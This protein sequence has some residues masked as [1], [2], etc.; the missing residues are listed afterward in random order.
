VLFRSGLFFTVFISY[1]YP[2]IVIGSLLLSIALSKGRALHI[3]TGQVK[4]SVF[5]VKYLQRVFIWPHLEYITDYFRKL[6]TNGWNL[7]RCNK[8]SEAGRWF[9]AE[10]Y[11]LHILVTV[12]PQFLMLLPLIWQYKQMLPVER[13]FLVWMA[14]GLFFFFITKLKW[15]LFLGEGE[16]YLEYALFPSLF[17]AVKYFLEFNES[18]V[19]GFLIYSIVSAFYYVG[20]YLICYGKN[21]SDYM[22]TDFAFKQF[23]NM[24]SGVIWPIGSFHYQ[25]L[26]RSNFPVL[27][28]GGNIDE[29]LISGA[30]FMLVYG[31]YP[32]PSG[33]FEKIIE[34]Y[35][36]SYIVSNKSSVEYYAETIVKRPEDFYN[37]VN[38]LFET[39]TL[40]A[41]K[42]K[43]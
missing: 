35:N 41:Y 5:Y 8:V 31:N 25:A 3:I 10:R 17:I 19:Y 12:Y 14:A 7:L 26:Y 11:F 34:K 18:I 24:P 23:N 43:M 4:H 30:E 42:V 40:V 38:L 13:F 33:N 27:S 9:Y 37:N 1:F 22:E 28:H 29:R 16:R 21:N 32:Y 6:A 2:A 20:E 15:V 39:H 36:V